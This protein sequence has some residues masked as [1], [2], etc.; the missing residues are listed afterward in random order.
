V[1]FSG[2][3]GCSN[4]LHT[5]ALIITCA[6]ACGVG[7]HIQWVPRACCPGTLC[8]IVDLPAT[9]DTHPGI[10]FMQLHSFGTHYSAFAN[11]RKMSQNQ[12][13]VDFEMVLEHFVDFARQCVVGT[14]EQ[15]RNPTFANFDNI[16]WTS[17]WKLLLPKTFI[18]D[19]IENFMCRWPREVTQISIHVRRSDWMKRE[20]LQKTGKGGPVR[21]DPAKEQLYVEA[22]RVVEDTSHTRTL[23]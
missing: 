9:A 22:D 12:L 4:R 16:D 2:D 14:P 21:P 19:N 6:N 1:Q 13:V 8:E 11:Q 17:A 3:W 20:T 5:L 18:I 10:P 15:F 23:T 7:L